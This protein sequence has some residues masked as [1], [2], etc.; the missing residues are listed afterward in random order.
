MALPFGGLN[1]TLGNS[2]TFMKLGLNVNLFIDLQ[3]PQGRASV[4]EY[5]TIPFVFSLIGTIIMATS[6]ALAS[7]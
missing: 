7:S 4:P 2:K 5:V 3:V 1:V 6:C